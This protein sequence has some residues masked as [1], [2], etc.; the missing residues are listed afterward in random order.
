MQRTEVEGEAGARLIGGYG[1]GTEQMSNRKREGHRVP[2]DANTAMGTRTS[3][4]LG[5]GTEGFC[6]V[7]G[8][9][10]AMLCEE[11]KWCGEGTGAVGML[12]LRGLTGRGVK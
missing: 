9:A 2:D 3:D 5:V 6:V 8:Y 7:D 11:A 12:W 4:W 1:D 10:L